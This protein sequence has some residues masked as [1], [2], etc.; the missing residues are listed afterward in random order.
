MESHNLTPEALQALR[1]GAD[2]QF[3]TAVEIW[4][5]VDAVLEPLE[6]AAGVYVDEDDHDDDDDDGDDD[7]VDAAAAGP[8]ATWRA[9]AHA[10][11]VSVDTLRRRRKK[12]GTEARKPHFNNADDARDWWRKCEHRGVGLVP[13]SPPPRRAPRRAGPSAQGTVGLT[14]AAVK[15]AGRRRRRSK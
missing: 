11:G 10:V 2:G 9:V 1:D 3:E 12:W 7:P 4:L 15:P 6:R 5:E 14:L 13:R 8:V